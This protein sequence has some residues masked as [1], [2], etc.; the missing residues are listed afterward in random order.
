VCKDGRAAT[1]AQMTF[2]W[3]RASCGGSPDA[4]V[5]HMRTTLLERMGRGALAGTFATGAMSLFM[6]GARRANWLGTPPPKKL[7]DRLL[8]TLGHPRRAWSSWPLTALNHAAFGA[9]AGVPFAVVAARLRTPV[10]RALAGSVYGALV[11][12]AMYQGVLPALGVMAKPRWDRPGRPTAM[13]LAHVI[14][15][16]C[17]GAG[18]LGEARSGRRNVRRVPRKTASPS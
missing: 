2:F 7:T 9:A 14:Y 13:L 8:G 17:L 1:A 10:G 5:C 18:A 12:S 3:A 6:L 11:W 4:Y 16:A 15:G